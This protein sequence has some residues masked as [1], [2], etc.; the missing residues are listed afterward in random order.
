MAIQIDRDK[1]ALLGVSV[2]DVDLAVLATMSGLP[3]GSYRDDEGVDHD[4]VVRLPLTDQAGQ[5]RRAGFGDLDR[6]TVAARA[7]VVPLR[8]VALPQFE[9]VAA[10]IDH[11]DLSRAVT[12]TANVNTAA[13][14]NEISVTQAIIDQ[15]DALS[16][17]TG[18]RVAYGGK[19]E[20]QQESFSSL[21]GAL[22]VAMLGIFAVLVLQFG[23]FKQPLI[24]FA[25]IPLAT[26]GAFPALLIT[27]YTFSFMAFIGFTSLVG[28]VVNNSILLVDLAN[29]LVAEGQSV[30]D[31]VREAGHTR[32][33]PI[34]L[35]T[36]TTIG[37]LLPLTLTNSDLWSPLGWV[38][39]GGLAVSTVLTLVVVPVLYERLAPELESEPA[40]PAP[41]A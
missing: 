40:S 8:Q 30:A 15:I 33:A 39:I 26:V 10:R 7:G 37:G 27:G 14:F 18:Y 13:G 23:S 19:L 22:I 16:L 24:I 2:A 12:V 20:A 3:V 32:F 1:A 35:T 5:Q 11:V 36:M 4:I 6:V 38:I 28:I 25:A 31:A 34:L 21:G 41:T 17:P 9:P 29:R